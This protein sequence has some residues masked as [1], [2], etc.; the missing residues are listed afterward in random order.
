M[1]NDCANEAFCPP[2]AVPPS[3]STRRLIV[4]RVGGPD[5]TVAG[6]KLSTPVAE[7]LGPA[8][9]APAAELLSMTKL[10]LWPASLAGPVK[11]PVAQGLTVTA[12]ASSYSA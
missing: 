5:G 12:P 1:V 6:V 10:T 3:S 2:L 4:A 11:I 7:T 9:N 8:A